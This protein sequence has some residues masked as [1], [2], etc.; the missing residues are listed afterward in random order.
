MRTIE[1]IHD[2]I[3][4]HFNFDN[5]EKKRER[6]YQFAAFKNITYDEVECWL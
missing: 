5:T 6:F 4:I 3:G 2:A 1:V